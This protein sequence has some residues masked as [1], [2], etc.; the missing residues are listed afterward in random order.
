MMEKRTE[1]PYLYVRISEKTR[2]IRKTGAAAG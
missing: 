1:C 2:A